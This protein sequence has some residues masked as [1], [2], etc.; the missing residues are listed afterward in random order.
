LGLLDRLRVWPN[1]EEGVKKSAASKVIAM[2][3]KMCLLFCGQVVRALPVIVPKTNAAVRM[4]PKDLDL[5]V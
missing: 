4:T 2:R 5:V 1:A 3:F